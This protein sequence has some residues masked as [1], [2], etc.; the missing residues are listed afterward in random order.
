[1]SLVTLSLQ[2][3]VRVLHKD[4]MVNN[5]NVS[6]SETRCSATTYSQLADFWIQRRGSNAQDNPDRGREA[7]ARSRDAGLE[8]GSALTPQQKKSLQRGREFS[9]TEKEVEG[10]IKVETGLVIEVR[11]EIV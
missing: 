1:M 2:L 6:S 5:R 11:V 8:R 4:V 3:G 9:D 7:L 10:R